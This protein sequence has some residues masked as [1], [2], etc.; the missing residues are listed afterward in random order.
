[1]MLSACTRDNAA[2]APTA[3]AIL[4][5][6][7]AADPAQYDHIP[8]TKNW[9]NPYLIVRADGVV[10]Y[11]SADSAEIILKP[12]Q[13]LGALARLPKSRWPYGRVVAATETAYSSEQDGIALR[14]N[15]GLVG[16][17]LEEANV[18]IRWV[19]ES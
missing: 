6:I 3:E 11:D 18:A 12:E 16:G 7:P 8:N 5:A 4:Q 19:P 13:V 9:R 17:F 14:R 2:K 1:M 10:L 15:K